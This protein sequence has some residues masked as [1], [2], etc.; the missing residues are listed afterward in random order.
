MAAFGIAV[1]IEIAV[2]IARGLPNVELDER[3]RRSRACCEQRCPRV[4]LATS[5]R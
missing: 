4:S 3:D 1:L 5:G 2:K